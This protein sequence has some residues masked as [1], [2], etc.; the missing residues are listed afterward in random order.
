MLELKRKKI[1]VT[2]G[3]GFLGR[4]LLPLLLEKGAEVSCLVRDPG[5]I[6]D[7]RVR[8]IKGDLADGTGLAEAVADQDAIIHMAA[9]LFGFGWNDYLRANSRAAEN[10]VRSADRASRLVF[11]SSLAASGPSI[12][13]ARETDPENPVSAYGWSKL[14]SEK[15]IQSAFPD[16]LIFRP[17]IIYGSGDR[18]LLP[19]FRS[20]GK[21]FAPSPG[22]RDEFPASAIHADDVARAIIL[23]IKREARGVYHLSDHETRSMNDLY[24]AMGEAQGVRSVKTLRLPL[25][26][27]KVAAAA[28]GVFGK[29][30]KSIGLASRPPQWNLDKYREAAQIGWIANTE[31]IARDLD[32]A[33]E[34]DLRK[35]MAEA[36]AGY[37]AQGWL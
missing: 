5:K 33:P 23:G 10:L 28:T 14:L 18:G 4:H 24:R 13:G 16:A 8:I 6:A 34:I 3:S 21:G 15:I 36:V 7:S 9:L 11:V 26:L 35:G 31:K 29:L 1:L 25:P 17:P 27:M 2:G 20:A 22:L 19:I 30:A 32:F 37:R 12:E